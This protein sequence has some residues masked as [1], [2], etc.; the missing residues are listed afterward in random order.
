MTRLKID[1]PSTALTKENG[2]FSIPTSHLP[3]IVL[4]RSGSGVANISETTG[5]IALQNPLYSIS[6]LGATSTNPLKIQIKDSGGQEVFSERF[7]LPSSARLEGVTSFDS[8]TKSG[9]YVLPGNAGISFI[10]NTSTTPTLPS[11]GYITDSSKHA[12]AGISAQGDIYV[13]DTTYSL[14]Y[15]TFGSYVVIRLKDSS[16][17]VTASMLYRVDAEYVMR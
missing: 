2:L 6:V 5:K 3:D 9:L 13:L 15:D 11:G 1:T 14:S 8:I 16:G 17:Q 7:S 10:K 12:I 4:K